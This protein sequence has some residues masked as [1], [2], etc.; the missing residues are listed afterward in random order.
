MVNK[1]RRAYFGKILREK[2]V[3]QPSYYEVQITN[4]LDITFP[5]LKPAFGNSFS[6]TLFFILIKYKTAEKIAN[7]REK[8]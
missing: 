1:F 6:T 3:K 2:S 4:I 8:I 5:E 7:M